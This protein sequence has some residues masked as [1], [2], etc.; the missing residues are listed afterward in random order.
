M[1]LREHADITDGT[2]V[3]PREPEPVL[4]GAA[5]PGPVAAKVCPDIITA[6]KEIAG[7]A[8]QL[9]LTGGEVL[10]YHDR[11]YRLYHKMYDDQ[12]AYAELMRARNRPTF[13]NRT[14]IQ[15]RKYSDC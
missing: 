1:F 6:R 5:L 3:L 8:R 2:P 9:I 15:D 7:A 14:E 13:Q 12:L 4:L 10:D 11:K